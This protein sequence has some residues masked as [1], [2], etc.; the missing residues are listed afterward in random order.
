MNDPVMPMP[1]N[2]VTHPIRV[3]VVED[4]PV[5]REWLVQVLDQMPG[6][7]VI[8]TAADGEEAIAAAIRLK[9]DIITMD[10]HMPRMNGLEATRRIMETSPVPIVIV[11]GSADPDDVRTTFSAMEAG[12]LAFVPCPPGAGHPDHETGIDEL[13][14]TI[15]AMAEVKVVRRWPSGKLPEAGSA[16]ARTV[17]HGAIE[18]VALGA[19]TGGPPVLQRILAALPGNFPVPILVVQHMATGFLQGFGE[20][21][22]KSCAVQVALA[23]DGE[24]LQPSRVYI[25]PDGFQMKVT[26]GGRIALLLEEPEDSLRPAVSCLFRSV[27]AVYGGT[28]LAGLLTG[29]GRDG[30][31]ELKLLRDG[32]A[33]TFVQD[34]ES[35]VVYGMPGE[36][37]RLDGA[38]FVLSPEKIA[39]LL[40]SMV[41]RRT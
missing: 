11:S 32:G 17:T 19:S 1:E 35:S 39:P 30:A 27:A 41:K 12:A 10:I 20:W 9:P 31:R 38:E 2:P 18:V 28:A 33:V 4:T 29:M 5:V 34:R 36:A 26:R 25:A 40:I 37:I 7:H 15:R 6:I 22:S 14:R 13:L 23:V 3:L 24:I 16:L 21:L 8:A